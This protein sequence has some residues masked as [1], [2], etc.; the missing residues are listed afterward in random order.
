[1][2]WIKKFLTFGLL[3]IGIAIAPIMANTISVSAASSSLAVNNLGDSAPG[4]GNCPNN[5]TLRAAIEKAEASQGAWTI[6]VPAGTI[7]LTNGQLTLKARTSPGTLNL[8]IV[9]AG[10]DLTIIDAGMKSRGFYFGHF[11]GVITLQG[12]TVKHANNTGG[13]SINGLP[14]GSGGAIYNETDLTLNDVTL[15][16]SQANQG[17]GIFTQ[18]G[19]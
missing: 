17:G 11:S 6:T 7:N 4:S 15:S 10:N 5:C 12:L 14:A 9:G 13:S 1:M 3:T 8:T 16:D 2:N 19:A 18:F